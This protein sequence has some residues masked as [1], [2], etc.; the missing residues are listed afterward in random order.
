MRF[1]VVGA[2]ATGGYF[3]GRLL[4]A[5][6]DVTFLVRPGRAEQLAATGLAITSPAG[7]ASLPSPPTV[8][9]ADLRGAFDVVI[10]SCK[11]YDLDAA[12][13]SVAPAVG[14]DTAVVPLL[15]G[16][17][18][19]DALDAR[20][21]PDR[22]LGGSCFISA[23]LDDAGRVAHVSDIHR[24]AFGERSGGRSPRVDAI[25]AAMAGAKFEAAASDRIVLEM[26]EKWVFLASL[27]GITC[28]TRSAVGDVVAAGG[29]DLAAALL[30]ECRS[31]AAAAGYSP[32]P[33]SLQAALGR[34]TDAGSAVTASMLG[35]VERRGRTEA[36]H[37]LGD[38]LRRRGGMADGDRSLLRVAYTAVKAAEARAARANRGRRGRDRDRDSRVLAGGARGSAY[39]SYTDSSGPFMAAG[40]GG[41]HVARR[42]GWHGSTIFRKLPVKAEITRADAPATR[43]VVPEKVS[44]SPPLT[45]SHNCSQH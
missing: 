42:P 7:D 21:G 26:W 1:L 15:N 16:M 25:A 3:G 28:L 8:L 39:R 32:R 9:A 18:H 34:L 11:A 20:F 41:S 24:L 33:E 23:R 45:D 10:L 13:E 35:D 44:L 31:V 17:R 37:I 27:A 38:L 12:I 2:G 40:T 43:A 19:L 29:A 4:E 6:R 30:E 22:V 14:P 36:D 5:G